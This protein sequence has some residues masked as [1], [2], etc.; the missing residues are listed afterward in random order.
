MRVACFALNG[1]KYWP[2]HISE[3]HSKPDSAFLFP[4][5][6][7]PKDD[8][9]LPASVSER[10][11]EARQGDRKQ[12]VSH[13]AQSKCIVQIVSCVFAN[14]LQAKEVFANGAFS[15]VTK[16]LSKKTGVL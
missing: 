16:R 7:L 6:P 13:Y 9:V 4:N 2:L 14:K 12:A 8:S 5:S 3:L 10:G 15:Q 1:V 11:E